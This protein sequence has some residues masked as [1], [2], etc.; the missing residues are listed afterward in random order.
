[1]VLP[2]TFQLKRHKAIRAF[3][4]TRGKRRGHKAQVKSENKG[5]IKIAKDFWGYFPKCFSLNKT[6]RIKNEGVKPILDFLASESIRL[7]N[8][9]CRQTPP[10]SSVNGQIERIFVDD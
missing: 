1:V 6:P 7:H 9:L 4:E 3:V 2:R 5:K 8:F 10:T